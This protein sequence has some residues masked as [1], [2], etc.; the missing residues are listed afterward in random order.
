MR[1]RLPRATLHAAGHAVGAAFLHP[2]PTATQVKHILGSAAYAVR[3]LR[4]GQI[5]PSAHI[6]SRSPGSLRLPSWWMS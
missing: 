5:P 2:L 3:T 4:R 1:G 6:T